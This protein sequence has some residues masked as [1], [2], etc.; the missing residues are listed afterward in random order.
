MCGA[1]ARA[2]NGQKQVSNKVKIMHVLSGPCRQTKDGQTAIHLAARNGHVKCLK[3]LL[4][5]GADINTTV[6]SL[7]MNEAIHHPVFIGQVWAFSL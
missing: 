5:Q 1:T 6:R 4:K 2:R 7:Y 3:T